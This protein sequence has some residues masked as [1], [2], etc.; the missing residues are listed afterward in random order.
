MRGNAMKKRF[1][2]Q[3]VA[4]TAL[5]VMLLAVGCGSSGSSSNSAKYES[6]YDSMG[7]SAVYEEAAMADSSFASNSSGSSVGTVAD[8]SRKLITTM[9]I[10]A[11]TDDLAAVVAGVESKVKELGGYIESS[12]I[13]N[14]ASYSSRV[15]KTAGITARIPKNRLDEFV[16]LVEGSTNITNKS[17]NVEDV[18]LS[19]VDIESRK[20]S[21]RTEEKRLLEILESAETVEDVIAVEDKLAD[22][23]YELESIES[24]LRSYDNRIDYS[25]VYLD[26]SEVVTFTPVEKESATT[27]M[28]KGFLQSVGEVVEAVVE[29]AVWFVIHIPQMILII[30]AIALVIIIIRLIDNSSKKRR[31]KKMQMM[32]QNQAPGNGPAGI[33]PNGM[34]ASQVQNMPAAPV[35]N[36]PAAPA[37]NAPGTA[38]LSAPAGSQK[39]STD[40]NK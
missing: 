40:G 8:T 16:D 29:F 22:V 36:T 10:S 27:R 38:P 17:V 32:N 30:I 20:N 7:A 37:Q 35:N 39:D 25:T 19:Y 4:A 23:R 31:I 18:T 2:R 33:S 1:Y 21:L 24:Q 9:N 34:P 14:N 15:S 3:C 28:G 6:A 13:S 11:E 26:I 5:L 12:N